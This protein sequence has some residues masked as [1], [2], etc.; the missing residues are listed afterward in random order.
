MDDEILLKPISKK[1]TKIINV[2]TV[3]EEERLNKILNNEEREH[4][5][6]NIA[7]L[8]LLTG[9]RIGEVLARSRQDVNFKTMTLNINNTITKD[10]IGKAILG[11]HTKTYNKRTNV[12]KGQRYFPINSEIKN[13]LKEELKKKVTNM[14]DLLFLDY[15][16]NTFISY[17]EINSWLVRLNDKY[18][19]SDK[20]LTSHVLRHTFIT[21]L[22]E[23]GVDI[24]VIQYLVGHTNNSKITDEL[25]TSLSDNFISK[26]LEKIR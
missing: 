1:K 14:Y 9:M 6:R 20:T 7:K 3:E 8:Q 2:L 15:K 19:I 21:R 23:K 11:K 4:K 24:K 17:Q 5:Y 16:N 12:D 26:E 18:K 25:Y 22:R 13:I 10:S